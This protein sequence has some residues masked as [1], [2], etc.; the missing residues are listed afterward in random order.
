MLGDPIFPFYFMDLQIS[1]ASLRDFFA[2][3][4][5]TDSERSGTASQ[6]RRVDFAAVHQHR[7][8]A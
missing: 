1:G 4:L 7:P 5:L 8:G 6:S 2:G 3:E